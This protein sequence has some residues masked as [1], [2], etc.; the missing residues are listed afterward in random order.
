MLLKTITTV[1]S[2]LL[3]VAVA[4]ALQKVPSAKEGCALI[5]PTREAQFLIF[6]GKSESEIRL[7]LRNNSTCAI[8]V[9]T[10]D[11]YPTAIKKLPGGGGTLET[12]SGSQDGLRLA[13]HY[14]IQNNKKNEAAKPAYGWGDS[15]FT[16]EIP[17]GQSIVFNVPA[18]HFKKHYDIAVP[19]SYPWEDKNQTVNTGVGGVMHLVHFLPGD[20]P[21]EALRK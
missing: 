6:E 3:A 1:G 15:V 2:L 4:N 18:S 12:V 8:L 7:R 16:Y 11:H 19:F 5:D 13:L 10:D 17:P 20:L 21:A 14:F 9:E